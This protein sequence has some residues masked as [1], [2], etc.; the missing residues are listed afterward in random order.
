LLVLHKD[1]DKSRNCLPNLYYGT[2]AQ[3]ARD[4]V[5]NGKHRPGGV[6]GEG[7]W[8]SRLKASDALEIVSL[9]ASGATCQ[10]IANSFGVAEMTIQDV[11]KGKTWGWLTGIRRAA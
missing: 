4:K 5:A 1:D 8:R 7:H 10:S 11:T 3:N 2:P 6:R 9:R